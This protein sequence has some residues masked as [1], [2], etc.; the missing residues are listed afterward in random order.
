MTDG[1]IKSYAA[2]QERPARYWHAQI[3]AAKKRREKWLKDAEDSREVYSTETDSAFNIHFSNVT[4]R[5]SARFNSAPIPDVRP[6]HFGTA[7]D[8]KAA[9]SLVERGLSH[10][11]DVYDFSAVIKAA[12]LSDEVAGLGQVRV[13][14]DT[15]TYVEIDYDETGQEVPR[16]VIKRESA[17]AVFV[18]HDRYLEGPA[19]IWEETPWIAYKQAWSRDDLKAAGV[20]DNII[21]QLAFASTLLNEESCEDEDREQDEGD[22]AEIGIGLEVGW[23]IWH[24]PT[25]QVILLSESYRDDVLMVEDDPV[26]RLPSFFPSPRPLM[27]IEVPG[28]RIP[29]CPYRLYKHH[30]EQL[31][32]MTRRITKLV[33]ILRYRGYRAAELGSE[34]SDLGLL[35]D[36]EF[37]PLDGALQLKGLDSAFWVMPVNDIIKVIRE[38]IEAREAVK[39]TV[40]EVTGISDVVRGASDPSETATAQEIK[41]NFGSLRIHDAQR[42]VQRFVRD[43]FRLK[44]DIIA[45]H[46]GDRTLA[47][48][49]GVNEEDPE[50]MARF[51][52]ALE[53]VRSDDQRYFRV[54]VETDSTIM[55]DVTRSQANAAKFLQ[56]TVQYGQGFMPL[57]QMGLPAGPV[58]K[59]F[60]AIS[61]NFK[62]GKQAELAVEEFIEAAA[63]QQKQQEEQKPQKDAEAQE[64]QQFN[65]AVA[66][67]GA[68]VA[69]QKEAADAA[70]AAAEAEGQQIENQ[71][72]AWMGPQVA[73]D[74]VN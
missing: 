61:A 33:R 14:W 51:Q 41:A 66:K 28:T 18:P 17:R 8:A 45:T 5:T 30:A 16:T 46:F 29:V 6:L 4:T 60:Q 12:V 36:G 20:A 32:Q 43:V 11:A 38:L 10:Q 21:K 55:G 58:L 19:M 56:A 24:K 54:D 70:K 9:A 44:A 53:L 50:S 49:D 64:D 62:L 48:I 63:A 34:I 73:Q 74:F 72:H 31:A 22:K 27:A 40:Y 15:E 59:L 13:D 2:V 57:V 39:A 3:K 67:Q 23:Q 47:M 42:E 69:L 1:M 52:E 65:R 26:P 68:Q 37:A 25:R 7:R 71:Q 35:D